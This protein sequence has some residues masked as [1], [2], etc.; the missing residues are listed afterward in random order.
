MEGCKTRSQ[1]PGLTVTSL[2]HMLRWHSSLQRRLWVHVE[3]TTV[4]DARQEVMAVQI[5]VELLHVQ[6]YPMDYFMPRA[7][8]PPVNLLAAGRYL[9]H[10]N[11][12]S[13]PVTERI[14]TKAT[15]ENVSLCFQFLTL[16]KC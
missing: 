15:W 5:R 3:V 11:F 2:V 1:Q 10:D 13:L 9:P 14:Y 7:R 16:T 6:R 4:N 8:G 12:D